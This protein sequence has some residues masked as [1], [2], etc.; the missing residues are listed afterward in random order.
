[1]GTIDSGRL[2][3]GKSKGSGPSR[4]ILELK[5]NG[6]SH[7]DTPASKGHG[8]YRQCESGVVF[9]VLQSSVK[10][11]EF[12]LSYAKPGIRKFATL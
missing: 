2:E 6:D 5:R 12:D 11:A 8:P 10:A 1:M 3:T 4:G 7:F 9:G